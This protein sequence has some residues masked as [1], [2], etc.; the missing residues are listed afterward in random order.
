MSIVYMGTP[1]YAAAILDELISH[2]VE[3]SLV[4]TQPDKKVGRKQI[5]TAPPVKDVAHKH[6]I[7]VAQPYKLDE[8]YELIKSKNP[9]YIIVAAYGQILS[10]KV[11][12]I[13]L[14]LNLHASILP[15][16][17]GAAP[18]QASL[19]R[20]D[21]LTGITI[22]QMQKGL[23][24]GEIFAFNLIS[25]E[26]KNAETLTNSL[27]STG[28]KLLIST[29]AKIEKIRPLEQTNADASYVKKITK[30]DALISFYMKKDE[31]VRRSNAFAP[32]IAIYLESG[33]QILEVEL[34]DQTSDQEAGKIVATSKDSVIVAC[35]D[36]TVAI[37]RVQAP[38]KNPVDSTSYINGKRL[39]VGDF[40][41]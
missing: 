38:S 3:V 7:E 22:M 16:F 32:W 6:N 13:A 5:L 12:D 14:C 29:L 19:I 8:I 25:T 33:L 35:M 18:V 31:L 37:K 11:L 36:G 1:D 20:G 28:A 41:A 24:T 27:A 39:K 23:D 10:Q 2:G 40:F 17:R 30:Q 34:S 21:Q 4:V 15:D 9:S 26:G